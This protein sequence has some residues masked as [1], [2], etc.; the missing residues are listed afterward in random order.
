MDRRT[1]L[2]AAAIMPAAL[3]TLRAQS[4]DPET[5]FTSIFD[6]RTLGG[7]SVQDGPAS[8]FRVEDNAI[9]V[10]EGSNFPAWLRSDK[11]YRELRLPL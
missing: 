9:V 2:T 3:R 6:G 1:F 8:A 11:Q 7:W 5:G 4:Q 10:D